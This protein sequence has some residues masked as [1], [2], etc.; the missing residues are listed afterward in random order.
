MIGRLI[1]I[2]YI[3]LANR[4]VVNIRLVSGSKEQ[5]RLVRW[6]TN[7]LIAELGAILPNLAVGKADVVNSKT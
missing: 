6:S 5:Q 7:Q 1:D 3:T 2:Q 4:L